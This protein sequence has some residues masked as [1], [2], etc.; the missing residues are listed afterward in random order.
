M[1]SSGTGGHRRAVKNLPLALR[2]G[3]GQDPLAKHHGTAQRPNPR[4]LR[5]DIEIVCG[6]RPAPSRAEAALD[7][8]LGAPSVRASRQAFTVGI[9]RIPYASI[10]GSIVRSTPTASSS[11]AGA[12][13]TSPESI[14]CPSR[15]YGRR[16]E[17][18]ARAAQATADGSQEI[19]MVSPDFVQSKILADGNPLHGT[20]DF[21]G[22]AEEE[23]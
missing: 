19:R 21:H 7:S 8:M 12:P 5:V 2:N 1:R 16:G 22:P 13:Y 3:I 17:C 15:S 4:V 10:R 20:S 9:P 6:R 23:L 18:S 11:P 14:S